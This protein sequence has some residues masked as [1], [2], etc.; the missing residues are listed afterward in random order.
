MKK[1]F[2]VAPHFPPSSLP[3]AQRV[4]MLARH[5]PNIGIKLT[6][7]TT[8]SK[9]REEK[10]D[11]WMVELAGNDYNLIKVKSFNQKVTRKFGIGD[12]GLRMLPFLFFSLLK[13]CRKEKP[14]FILYPVPPWYILTIAPWIKKLTGIPYAIDFI[15][16]W[17]EGGELPKTASRKRKISQGLA[18]KLE[19]Y[20]TKHASVIYAVSK[21]INEQLLQRHP[22]LKNIPM[23]AVPYG[24]DP[25]DF[26]SIAVQKQERTDCLIRYIGAVWDDAYPVLEALFKG[27]SKINKDVKIEFIGTGYAGEGLAKPQLNDFIK[28]HDLQNR[29]TE[30]PLRVPYKKA[31]ELTK[32]SDFLLLFGGMQAYYAASKLFGLI[33]SK[34]PFFALLHRDSFPALFLKDLG[35][36]YLVQYSEKE[37]DL[38]INHI[39]EIKETLEKLKNNFDSFK[40]IDIEDER[41]QK[42]TAEGMSKTFLSAMKKE[43]EPN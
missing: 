5:L 28:K 16:P 37:N 41:I 7:F 38:P 34:K 11:A 43:V 8:Y 13:A 17:V 2:I 26:S 31:V 21:G 42:H 10:E 4:R 22:D 1:L 6:F 23:Y 36:P 30:E 33:V 39:E 18:L 9:Y 29:V 3:P 19:H 20:V 25:T 12:L 24:A 15:D 32:E 27:F 35:Y 14:D 40:P